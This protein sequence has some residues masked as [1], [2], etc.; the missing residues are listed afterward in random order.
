MR[1]YRI[2]ITIMLSMLFFSLAGC[3]GQGK[4]PDIKSSYS[5]DVETA[6]GIEQMVKKADYIVVGRYTE[7][8]SAYNMYRDA[9]D[10]S[11]PDPNNYAGGEIYSFALEQALKGEP[12]TKEIPVLMRAFRRN[13]YVESDMVTDR[14]G[15]ITKP[16]TYK[17]EH[18]F[19]VKNPYYFK[20]NMN[21]TYILFLDCNKNGKY[22]FSAVPFSIRIAP[23]GKA[24]LE[25]PFKGASE[26]FT[27]KNKNGEEKTI[28][29]SYDGFSIE[30]KITGQ[31]GAELIKTIGQLVSNQK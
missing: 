9:N 28:E 11:K 20:P 25:W 15:L 16:A 27:F 30:D 17:I 23:T 6:I 18:T 8:V 7:F 12:G 22:V 5:Y 3:T 21:D 24:V 1:H 26:T 29:Y 10:P 13:R 19:D 2:L 4:K 14:T 31:K